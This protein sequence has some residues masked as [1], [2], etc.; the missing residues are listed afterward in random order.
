ME[1]RNSR[2]ARLSNSA[3]IESVDAIA[4]QLR[5]C[6]TD[7][8]YLGEGPARFHGALMSHSVWRKADVC[9]SRAAVLRGISPQHCW[10]ILCAS[11]RSVPLRV[12]WRLIKDD[13]CCVLGSQTPMTMYL[14]QNCHAFI[15]SLNSA[16]LRDHAT[17]STIDN[18]PRRGQDEF[19]ILTDE[20]RALLATCINIVESED[21][22]NSRDPTRSQLQRSHLNQLLQSAALPIFSQFKARPIDSCTK[23]LRQAAVS[24]ACAYI[25]AHLNQP[26]TLNNLCVASGV[27]A[28]TLEYGFAELLEV[29]P[30]SY[31]KSVRLSRTYKDLKASKSVGVSIAK[32]AN[33]WGFRH[34]GQFS[35]DY[36]LLFNESP[37]A[38][39]ARR[40][41][42]P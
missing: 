39:Q 20:Q 42:L 10:S 23:T 38:T 11:T 34:M 17:L 7:M 22:A 5:G 28:R 32:I 37:S 4:M 16:M 41:F 14:P 3:P 8:I 12:G 31:L 9:F 40:R 18:L 24:R 13:A 36:R 21:L 27:Q 30:M 35:R 33:R 19:R 15:L 26:I 25:D 1:S 29:A 2:T 6:C